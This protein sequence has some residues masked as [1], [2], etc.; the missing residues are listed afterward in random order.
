M[1]REEILQNFCRYVP[2]LLDSHDF[3]YNVHRLLPGIRIEQGFL[4]DMMYYRTVRT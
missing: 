1:T 4:E 2:L 3:D